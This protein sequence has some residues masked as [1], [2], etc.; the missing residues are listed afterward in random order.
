MAAELRIADF[1]ADGLVTA[2]QLAAVTE[3]NSSALTR[4]LRALCAIGILAEDPVDH[5][6]L[7]EIGLLLHTHASSSF[8][9]VVRFMTG[10]TRWRCWADLLGAVRTGI[11]RPE[12]IL[13]MHL[14]DY[15]AAHPAECEIAA[16]AMRA[17]SSSHLGALMDAL[18]LDGAQT[19]VDVGGG[20]GQFLAAILEAHPAARGILFDLPAVVRRAPEILSA[21]GV[22]DRCEIES[23]S[24]FKSVPGSGDVYLLKQILHDWDDDR[25]VAI[26][27]ACRSKM[28]RGAKLVVIERCIPERGEAHICVETFMTD[29]EMLVMTPGGRERTEQAFRAL[30]DRAGLAHLRTAATASSM[31]LFEGQR[32]SEVT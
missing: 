29:L 20:T 30:F 22:R 27:D 15:H 18:E 1:I 9:D 31:L 28:R 21:A 26:L 24:F 8:R 11:N 14:F 7:T 19:I 5:F 32:C 6:T 12:A 4:V 3:C 25:A 13:G 23:G 16:N 10:P 17:L 2:N